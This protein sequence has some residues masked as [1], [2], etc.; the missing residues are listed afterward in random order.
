MNVLK[1]DAIPTGVPVDVNDKEY[2]EYVY[3][4]LT[5]L[6]KSHEGIAGI[7][8]VQ[9]GIPAHMCVID[10]TNLDYFPFNPHQVL[11]LVNALYTGLPGGGKGVNEE[12]CL[13]LPDE[14]Y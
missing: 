4:K 3:L 7:A 10:T 11:C 6:V 2:L 9:L 14:L 12:A 8:A 5:E 1:A 13:S